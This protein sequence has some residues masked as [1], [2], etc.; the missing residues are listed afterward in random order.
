MNQEFKKAL[1]KKR[2]VPFPPGRKLIEKELQ[3]AEQDLREAKDRLQ[4]EKFKYA[5]ITAY[6]SMFHS[7]RA[8]L[9]N[10]GHREKSHHYL[11]VAIDALY[12]G[13]KEL[14]PRLCRALLNAMLL[15]EDAD[16]HSEFSKDGAEAV[17]ASADEF[18]A[19]A[20]KILQK[21]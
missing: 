4:N 8:L 11:A 1:E 13:T 12:V 15:R 9:Y 3:A 19:I 7:A 10:K 17:L 2:I 5:T 6:Y 21:S 20:R 14:E 16:Y 18:L